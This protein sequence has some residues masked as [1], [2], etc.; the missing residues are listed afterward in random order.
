MNLMARHGNGIA[1]VY[2]RTETD[3]FADYVWR[4]AHAV[5]FIKTR[6]QFYDVTGVPLKSK[7]AS[8]SVLVA[9]GHENY[10]ALCHSGIEGVTVPLF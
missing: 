4:A 7:G 3:W 9:Y 8:G 2:N 10:R 6:V 1:L 5:L